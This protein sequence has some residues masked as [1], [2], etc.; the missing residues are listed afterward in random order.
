MPLLYLHNSQSGFG[1][2]LTHYLKTVAAQRQT[3]TG[4][5]TAP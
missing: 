4:G 2:T 3:P 1:A 5:M